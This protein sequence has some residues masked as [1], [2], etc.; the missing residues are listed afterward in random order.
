MVET[1]KT[2]LI[3]CVVGKDTNEER[4]NE[5][6]LPK[7][8]IKISTARLLFDKELINEFAEVVDSVA[9]GIRGATNPDEKLI[10]IPR[11]LVD[12]KGIITKWDAL[13]GKSIE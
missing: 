1:E 10:G 12:K 3:K 9:E 4:N 13:G 2:I 7:S 6:W 8:Q 11:W 5:V